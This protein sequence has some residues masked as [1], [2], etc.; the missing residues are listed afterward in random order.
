M[1]LIFHLFALLTFFSA[2]A[3]TSYL[4]IGTYTKGKSEGIYVYDFN[5]TNGNSTYKSKI[6]ASNPSFLAVSPKQQYVYAALENTEG[7]VSAYTFNKKTGELTFINQQ[8]SGGSD[9]CFVETDKTGKWLAVANYSG[10]SLSIMPVKNGGGLGTSN[11]FIQ[12]TGSGPNKQRQ[13][14][15]HVHSTFFSADNKFLFTPDLGMDQTMIYSFNSVTGKL[16]DGKQPY[17][18]SPDSGGPRHITFSANNQYVYV[19]E[20]LTGT[21]VAY[22]LTSGKLKHV[23]TISAAEPGF[24]GFMGSAD[25]HTS[26]DGKFLYC[27]NRGDA[28]TITIFKINAANGKLTTVGYQSTL[29][30]APRNFSLDPSG[31]FLLVANQQSDNIIIF[32]RNKTTGLL[33]DTGKKIEVGS[34]VCLKWISMK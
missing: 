22:K 13:E 32:K 23:Q 29:G 12:H 34:P 4:L 20:E 17:I 26:A 6:K 10:G 33:T 9:P 1:K 15:A 30:I 28:N 18:A 27:S 2:S 5:S 7:Q 8:P 3:Q 19:M 31:N 25:I 14:K 16:T 11:Q 21:V 24:K